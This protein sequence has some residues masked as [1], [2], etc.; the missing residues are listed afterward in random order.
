MLYFY[1]EGQPLADAE[2]EGLKQSRA[3]VYRIESPTG[4]RTSRAF[5]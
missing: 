3:E 1:P 4:F 5:Y 2:Q